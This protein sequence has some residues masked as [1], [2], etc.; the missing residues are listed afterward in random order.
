MLWE[1]KTVQQRTTMKNSCGDDWG[2]DER[3]RLRWRG[4]VDSNGN[5]DWFKPCTKL[6][7]NRTAVGKAKNTWPSRCPGPSEMEDHRT[8]QGE[9]SSAS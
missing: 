6:V 5:A 1:G 8:A 7:V 9:P 4:H 2:R 3:V